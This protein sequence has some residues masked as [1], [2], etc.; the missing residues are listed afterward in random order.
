[1]RQYVKQAVDDLRKAK[2]QKKY[3]EGSL[4]IFDYF[5][6]ELIEFFNKNYAKKVEVE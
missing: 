6:P 4:V 3:K 2:L 1:M 5:E